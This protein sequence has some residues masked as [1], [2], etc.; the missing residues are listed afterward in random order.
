MSSDNFP[1]LIRK[2]SFQ[3]NPVAGFNFY[4][5][6]GKIN[7]IGRADLRLPACG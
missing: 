5:I 6:T 3:N 7:V 4:R 2:V 1:T